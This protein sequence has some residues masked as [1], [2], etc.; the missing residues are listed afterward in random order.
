WRRQE[1]SAATFSART[2]D[3]EGPFLRTGDL[4]FL[5]DGELFVTGRIKDL[6]ILRGRNHYPQDIE[7][8]VAR[9]HAALTGTGAAFS[10]DEAGE[11]RLVVVQ[12][13]ERH[14]GAGVDEIAEAVRRAVAEE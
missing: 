10:V 14:S 9:S 7:A 3:G 4:G 2:A 6:I 11:E 8:T 1:L 12:E 5:E 13:V